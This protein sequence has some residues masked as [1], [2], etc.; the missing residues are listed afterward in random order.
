VTTT[1]HIL[2]LV[3]Q[4][5]DEFED[6]PLDGSIRRVV[7]IANV[8][9]DTTVALR[10]SRD[11]RPLGGS[12]SANAR[13]SRLLMDD[14][15]TWEDPDGPSEEALSDYMDDRPRTGE[16]KLLAHSVAEIQVFLDTFGMEAVSGDLGRQGAQNAY[17]F[18]QFVDILRHRAFAQ[19]CFW[20]RTLTYSNTNE[21]IFTRFQ[22][23]VDRI[24]GEI[25][26]DILAKFN[27]VFRRMRDAARSGAA[28]DASEELSQA[29]MS[30]RRMLKS[31][32][33]LVYPAT[34]E[35]SDQ[36][37]PL[38]DDKYRNRIKEFTKGVTS[39]RSTREVDL[40]TLDGLYDRF[41]ALDGVAN[42]GVHADIALA[43]A[44]LCSIQTYIVAGELLRLYRSSTG[45]SV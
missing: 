33:D 38:D 10:F 4:T 8:L 7:R 30:C 45:G 9:G 27:S 1:D 19:L 14:P 16:G 41:V 25:A 37:N 3:Q 17:D 34:S 13:D 2:R 22:S 5:L 26:P 23:G 28:V 6:R 12:P 39:S 18:R 20:E 11:L 43:E 40:A 15:S 21:R 44:E 35:V 31:V 32:A 42:K 36:G 24:I 29:V